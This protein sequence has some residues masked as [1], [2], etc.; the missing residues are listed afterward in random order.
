MTDVKVNEDKRATLRLLDQLDVLSMKPRERKRVI[1]SMMGQ[2]RTKSRRNTASQKTITG[3]KFTPRTKRS[4]SRRRMLMGLT[5]QLSTKLKNDH[6]GVVGWSHHVPAAIAKTHQD[7]ATVE[8]NSIENKM[9]TGHSPSYFRKPLTIKQA[10]ALKRYG[11]RRRIAR[12]HGKAVWRRATTRW[13]KDNVT[14]GQAG[15]IQNAL[16][17]NGETRKPNRWKVKVPARP[18]LG[19]TQE[20]ADAYL[21]EMAET[22]LQRIRK[23]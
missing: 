23:A 16:V 5:K 9:H 4:K 20:D 22:A 18:F 17:H 21:T 12:K 7:G 6:R 19:A 15:L 13:I 8:C 1:R 10:R 2:T 11:F 3:Q 14:L